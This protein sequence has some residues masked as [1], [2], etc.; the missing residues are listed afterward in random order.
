MK[1]IK[2]WQTSFVLILLLGSLPLLKAQNEKDLLAKLIEEDR[3]AIEALVMYPEDTRVAILQ[4][5]QYPEALIKLESLQSETSAAFKAVLENFTQAEQEAI[6]DITRYPDLLHRLVVAGNGSKTAIAELLQDYPDAIKERATWVG[7]QFYATL[8]QIDQLE[9]TTKQTF[10]VILEAYPI[11]GRAALQQLIELP[12][13]LTLLTENIRL[14]ILAGDMYQKDPQWVLHKTDSLHLD[15][16]RRNAEEL[17]DWQESLAQDSEVEA[18]L[19]ASAVAYAEESGY[20][21][22]YYNYDDEYTEKEIAIYHYYHYPYWYGYP[23]WYA[24][25]RWR[26]FPYWY[27][28][29]FYFVVDGPIIVTRLPSY[30]FTHWYFYQPRHHYQYPR[31]SSHFVNH[32]NR[33]RTNRSGITVSV[34]QWK[35]R[36]QEIVSD[37]WLTNTNRQVERFREFGKF[38]MAREKN[39][40]EKPSRAVSQIEYLEKNKT[41]YPN[42][43][44]TNQTTLRK[45][46]EVK[47]QTAEAPRTKTGTRQPAD[48]ETTSNPRIIKKEATRPRT[49]PNT[50]VKKGVEYHRNTSEKAKTEATK[51]S[52]P[53]AA[54]RATI[55]KTQP[56]APARSKGTTTSKP[57]KKNE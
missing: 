16:A 27:D 36:N 41:R 40:M 32:Y 1:T 6:W 17:T 52:P 46:E 44:N 19:K 30:Y 8:Q 28:W 13:V 4:A 18:A 9:Q 38:E 56:P 33:H 51:P 10:Q 20:D 3:D 39:N 24:Y 48:K 54:P 29:G 49:Q 43:A 57:R 21:D 5:A 25:P 11:D 45:W 34:N 47:K 55:P 12:E 15:I 26:P 14:T 22:A 37:E 31:L 7:T 50:E 23:S 2:T 35:T 42:L 53:K